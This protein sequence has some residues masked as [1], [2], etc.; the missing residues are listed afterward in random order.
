MKNFLTY[1]LFF[2]CLPLLKAQ[3]GPGGV[4]TNTGSS[5]LKLWLQADQGISNATNGQSVNLWQDQ[6]GA[7]NHVSVNTATSEP[8]YNSNGANSMPYL[9]LDGNDYLELSAASADF[10]STESTVFLV[11]S[12]DW[13]G[14]PYSIAES[15][16]N[17][18][19][20][21]LNQRIYHHSSSGNFKF[22]THQCIG[23]LPS[24]LPLLVTAVYGLQ[25]LDIELSCNGLASTSNKGSAG[26]ASVYTAANRTVRIGKRISEHFTGNI[27]EV[28]IYNRKLTATERNDV[29]EYLRC[30]Y[31]IQN[32]T[33]GGLST[34]PCSTATSTIVLTNNQQV[35]LYPNPTQQTINLE[36]NQPIESTI[37][38]LDLTGKTIQT[39]APSSDYMQ[40][41]NLPE[42]P[43]GIYIIRMG[44][45][46]QKF[47]KN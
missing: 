35:N 24:T 10:N 7:N 31:D 13:T 43:N 44:Q 25:A 3:T 11:A 37:E 41:L 4:G 39:Y 47:I 36:S 2:L 14:A 23:N 32:Q 18:E 38:L 29:H 46:V 12:G 33:C 30:K 16:M 28:I 34:Q 20:T 21:M 15:G 9:S 22:L 1:S 40:S 6:S 5:S 8:T 17:N 27:Y 42:L 19:M 26:N 45:Y